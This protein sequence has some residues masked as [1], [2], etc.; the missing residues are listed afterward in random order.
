[1]FTAENSQLAASQIL[2]MFALGLIPQ[3]LN[4]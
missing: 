1:M 3:A 2:H 4:S